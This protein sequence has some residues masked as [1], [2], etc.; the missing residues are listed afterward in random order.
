LFSFA[1]AA[2]ET[3]IATRVGGHEVQQPAGS[4]TTV[5]SESAAHS[6]GGGAGF[7]ASAVPPAS[8]GA[9]TEGPVATAVVDARVVPVGATCG[10]EASAGVVATVACGTPEAQD[11]KSTANTRTSRYIVRLY[12]RSRVI[13]YPSAAVK[14]IEVPAAR[15]P[16]PDVRRKRRYAP[17]A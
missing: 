8:A 10:V 16:D 7:G 15:D 2:L 11:A 17:P 14:R 1:R 12:A 9:T 4:F 6:G 13:A 3:D 5:H